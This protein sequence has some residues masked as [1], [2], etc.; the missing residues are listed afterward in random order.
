[1]TELIE[2]PAKMTSRPGY[3]ERKAARD[4]APGNS[5]DEFMCPGTTVTSAESED[6]LSDALRD[7]QVRDAVRRFMELAVNAAAEIEDLIEGTARRAFDDDV[8]GLITTVGYVARG[9][10]HLMSVLAQEVLLAD[11]EIVSEFAFPD[12]AAMSEY[13]FPRVI[14]V[15]AATAAGSLA[16]FLTVRRA[17]VAGE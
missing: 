8:D 3:A 13:L 2:R 12:R 6:A 16:Q 10:S 14:A 4:Q 7:E 1:M 17:W 11:R 15:E 9:A 5:P